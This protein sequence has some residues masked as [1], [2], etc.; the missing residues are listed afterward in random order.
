MNY[1]TG[2][3]SGTVVFAN[4]DEAREVYGLRLTTQEFE[5]YGSLVLGTGV[6]WTAKKFLLKTNVVYVM[7][8]QPIMIGEYQFANL[9]ISEP[10]RGDYTLSGNYLALSFTFHFNKPKDKWE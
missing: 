1:K 9:E 10:T 4:D 7:N 5:Y 6:L 2:S 3:A 8:F